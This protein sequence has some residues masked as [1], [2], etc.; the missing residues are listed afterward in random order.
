M[1]GVPILLVTD[2]RHLEDALDTINFTRG[3]P[4]NESFPLAEVADAAVEAIKTRGAAM[5]QYGPSPGF[6]PLR[7][8]LAQW[9]G[10][11]GRIAT[12]LAERT[13]RASAA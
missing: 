11:M 10:V 12:A 3:V 5:L 13:A 1:I 8:W 7:E 2:S 9:Q 6:Q 4:A